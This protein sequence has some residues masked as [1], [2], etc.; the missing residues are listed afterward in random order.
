[1]TKPIVVLTRR[2][3]DEVERA[4][5]EHFDLRSRPD[6]RPMTVAEMQQAL[7]EADGIICTL[8][9]P[10]KEALQGGPWR[11]RILANFGAGTDHID[12]EAAR[13]LG[14]VVTNTPGALTDAT[15]DLA[16]ALILMVTRRLGEGEREVRAGEWTGWRPTH[17]LGN[18]LQG[19]TLGIIGFGRIGQATARRAH[20]GFGMKILYAG[21]NEVGVPR[22]SGTTETT[23]L[24][25]DAKAV[26][27][28][29]LL[30]TSDVISLHT[31]AT[32]ETIGMLGAERL[33]LMKKGSYLVN[34]ARGSIVDE[35]ALIDALKSGHLAGA[36]LD[37]YT[38]EPSIP[39]ELLALK[40][41]V[42]L[43]HLGSATIETRTAMGMR[44]V[45][46]LGA[47]FEGRPVLDPVI[48]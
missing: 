46:N 31:P 5:A 12:L 13:S 34:T 33:R 19:K 15:A 24:A 17:L 16:M 44:A 45:V 28:A 6:D 11:T 18:S 10:L 3:P 42:A 8:G 48:R 36:G 25:L 9:D 47:Y 29:E 26:G 4:A 32:P 35:A 21:R 30:G 37:V 14:M 38:R 1:M 22:R 2:L 41:V 40:N 20:L 39:V 27:L 23:S 7:R 43:P